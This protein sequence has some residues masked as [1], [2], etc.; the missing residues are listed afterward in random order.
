MINKKSSSFLDNFEAESMISFGYRHKDKEIQS[1]K[2]VMDKLK[3]PKKL[4]LYQY[5]WQFVLVSAFQSLL[6]LLNGSLTRN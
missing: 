5:F 3:K 2:H 6:V 4:Y 1:P